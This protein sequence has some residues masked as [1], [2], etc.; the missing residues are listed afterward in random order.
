MRMSVNAGLLAASV[1][2]WGGYVVQAQ[3]VGPVSDPLDPVPYRMQALQL[4]GKASGLT[5]GT[6]FN[7]AIS[8]IFDFT[9]AHR[10]EELEAPAGFEGGGHAHGGDDEHGH[11]HGIADGFGFRGVELTLSGTVDPYL[12]AQA[13][14]HFTEDE[15]EV[16]EAFATTRMLPAGLQLKAGKFLS[17][18]GYI[19]KQHLHEWLFVDQ[20]WMREYLLGEEGLNELGVQL[21][22]LPPTET[23]IRLGAEV[24]QGESAGV[25]NYIGEEGL[26]EKDGP[27]LFTG[28]AKLAPDL[29][30]H[31]A[32]QLG[33]S[34]GGS[35]A[36]QR[37]GLH[38]HGEEDHHESWDG[39]SWFA[40]LDLV[41]KYDG[42]GVMGHRN[43]TLQAEYLY[44]QLNL[45]YYSAGLHEEE[46]H[47]DHAHEEHDDHADEEHDD[48]GHEEHD[49]HG[50]GNA[51]E[52]K[53]DGLYVQA[54]YGFA[55]RWNAGLRLDVLGLINDGYDHGEKN[56]LGTSYRYTGQI[57]YAP[58]EFS[59]IRAQASYMDLAH[60]D[61]GHGHDEA[62]AWLVLLQYSLS[63]GVHGAHSF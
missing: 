36:F 17:D 57:T 29:G 2:V 28:F 31:H 50:H 11:S 48:H 21:S 38:A 1:M 42:K 30:D 44:R 20:P 26:R 63:L 8:A 10:T 61:H 15:V 37:A 9:Y 45:D 27:R 25:A 6:E 49:D 39:D 34:G 54:V 23:Y 4:Q 35:R 33:V 22:W 60:E 40:G 3:E 13:T 41:Y 56:E 51:Q 16:E 62:E 14:L 55:P 43:F 53:Q 24:L 18:V 7:P 58:S 19:N 59:L 12:D 47:A 5:T 52:W 32:V 46:E